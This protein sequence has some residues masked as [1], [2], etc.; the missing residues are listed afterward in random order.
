MDSSDSDND[1]FTDPAY[2]Q[3]EN[4]LDEDA[5]W[6]VAL[7]LA[8]PDLYFTDPSFFLRATE[9][10]AR[11][12]ADFESLPILT[13]L[14]IIVAMKRLKA[15][16]RTSNFSPAVKNLIVELLKEDGIQYPHPPFEFLE[17]SRF[18]ESDPERSKEQKKAFELLLEDRVS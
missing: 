4:G 3:L 15:L 14:E 16:S 11:G 7:I 18:I 8:Q 2:L 5:A 12:G 1:T 10:L 17:P 13:S 9:T 6:V